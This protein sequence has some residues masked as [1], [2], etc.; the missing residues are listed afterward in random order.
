MKRIM[1]VCLCLC[2]SLLAGCTESRTYPEISLD[3]GN[4]EVK[5]ISL[6][7]AIAKKDDGENFLLIITQTYCG[8][9]MNFFAESDAY[10][11]EAGSPVVRRWIRRPAGTEPDARP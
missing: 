1:A 10:T 3:P 6:D 7:D 9:C 11:Q 2:L 8:Y 5:S 4:G